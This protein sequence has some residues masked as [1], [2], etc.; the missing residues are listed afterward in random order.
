MNSRKTVYSA[1]IALA[2]A[3]TAVQPITGNEKT[4]V[5]DP[6]AT[7]SNDA[8]S[9][10][11][12]DLITIAAERMSAESEVRFARTFKLAK[13]EWSKT[14]ESR[15]DALVTRE[16]LDAISDSE[17]QELDAL[18]RRRRGELNPPSGE[19]ILR[20][21]AQRKMDQGMLTLLRRH[22]RFEPNPT[23]SPAYAVAQY[24]FEGDSAGEAS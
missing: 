17:L 24:R 15:F 6:R 19:E 5:T 23:G 7:I 9:I 11:T 18:Q 3:Q 20:Q 14:D 2:V 12:P 13:H 16:A 22:V 4:Q 21:Y 1:T 8:V 10:R